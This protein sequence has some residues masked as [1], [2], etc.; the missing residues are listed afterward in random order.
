MR[1]NIKW[2]IFALAGGGLLVG[3]I[4]VIVM[5]LLAT[6]HFSSPQKLTWHL[7]KG[8]TPADV[9]W[10]TSVTGDVFEQ[11]GQLD[12]TIYDSKGG[13]YFHDIAQDII[14]ER[15]GNKLGNIYIHFKTDC[16][17]DEAYQ[18]IKRM[19]TDWKCPAASFNDLEIW[20]DALA[21]RVSYSE[22]ARIHE[23]DRSLSFHPAYYPG[24]QFGKFGSPI[25]VSHTEGK[26]EEATCRF[27]LSTMI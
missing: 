6:K 4:M 21:K 2:L 5:L 12:L 27:T 24:G 25:Q 13:I 10:P 7:Y 26:P 19:M 3:G 22:F 23:H 20:H 11:K 9:G 14:C 18:T 17:A 15:K 16:T 8:A 1:S